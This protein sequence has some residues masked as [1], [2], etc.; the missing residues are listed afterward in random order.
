MSHE[1]SDD[2][3][4]IAIPVV[5][6]DSAPSSLIDYRHWVAHRNADGTVSHWSLF[7]GRTERLPEDGNAVA[8]SPDAPLVLTRVVAFVAH[9]PPAIAMA[10]KDDL[11]SLLP[12]PEEGPPKAAKD[13]VH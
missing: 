4:K 6:A 3:P 7:L 8:P 12:E 13:T 2:T 10:L 11:A 9:I 1:P 5:G